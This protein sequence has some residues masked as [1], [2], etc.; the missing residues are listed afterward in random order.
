MRSTRVLR[1]PHRAAEA[2][3]DRTQFIVGLLMAG[4]FFLC[5]A[6]VGGAIGVWLS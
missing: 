2:P 3:E 4:F 5:G 6:V 1:M